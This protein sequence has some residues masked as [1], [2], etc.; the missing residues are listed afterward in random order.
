ME[1][2]RVAALRGHEVILLEAA[3]RLG[4]QVLLAAR[5]AWRRDLVGIADWLAAEVRRLG[6]AVRHGVLAEAEDIL[7]L[8]PDVVVIATG[9]L[10]RAPAVPGGELALSSW[11]LLA[12]AALPEGPAL[13]YDEDG[14]HAAIALAEHLARAGRPVILAT[15]DRAAGRELGGASWPVYLGALAR[16]GASVLTDRRLAAIVRRGNGLIAQLVHVYGDTVEEHPVATVAAELGSAPNDT[17]FHALK[18]AALNR[19]VS[20]VTALRDWGPQPWF[21]APPGNGYLLFRTGDAVASRDIHAAMLD[22]LRL[23]KDL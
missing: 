4:G 16:A 21:R 8:A 22:A 15:P 20:D 11:D 13:V 14:R 1:A 17:L 5:A 18:D 10:P 12:G 23:M 9:G 3:E 6:V 7:A 2:A 19:G